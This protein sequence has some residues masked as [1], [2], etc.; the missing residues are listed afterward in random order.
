MLYYACGMVLRVLP[1]GDVS[2]PCRYISPPLMRMPWPVVPQPRQQELEFKIDNY[3]DLDDDGVDIPVPKDNNFKGRKLKFGM[4]VYTRGVSSLDS[5]RR[6][7]ICEYGTATRV[8]SV[9]Q[10]ALMSE[11]VITQFRGHIVRTNL[12]FVHQAQSGQGPGVEGVPNG[13][14]TSEG[15]GADGYVVTGDATGNSAS[16]SA[17]NRGRG[18]WS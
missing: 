13:Q 6:Q 2:G 14:Q 15:I 17:A 10:M 4:D 1:A 9:T 11:N 16:T 3:E 5:T 12:G 8:E 18:P 7:D